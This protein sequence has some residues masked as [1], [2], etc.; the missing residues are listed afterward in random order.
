MLKKLL[1]I[2]LL[3]ACSAFAQ[4][5]INVFISSGVLTLDVERYQSFRVLLNQNVTSVVLQ[6]T[7]AIPSN[8][9]ISITFTQDATGSRTVSFGAVVSNACTVGSTANS[10]TVCQI[11]FDGF[12]NTWTG[13][14]G[15]G[16]SSSPSSLTTFFTGYYGLAPQ[17][18]GAKGDGQV[19]NTCTANNGNTTVTCTAGRFVSADTGKVY[20]LSNGSSP[21]PTVVTGTLTF[22]NATTVTVSVAPNF[23]QASTAVMK[24]GTDDTTALRAWAANISAAGTVHGGYL[25]KGFYYTTKPLRFVA[26]AFGANDCNSP[27]SSASSST[28]NCSIWIQGAGYTVSSIW[29]A[30]AGSF[31]WNA[32][33]TSVNT[34]GMYFA[35]WSGGSLSGFSVNANGTAH[36]T[37]GQ[38]GL[39]AG[40][41]FD[42][43]AHFYVNNTWVQG[44]HNTGVN[45]AGYMTTGNGSGVGAA[46]PCAFESQFNPIISEI[47]DINLWE[48]NASATSEK[49]TYANSFFEHSFNANVIIGAGS[50]SVIKQL[51]FD[52][53]H[54]ITTA[55]GGSAS[56]VFVTNSGVS[57][58]VND[59]IVIANSR[60]Q[61]NVTGAP[62]LGI[63]RFLS[64]T[65]TAFDISNTYIETTGAPSYP[66]I[67]I[68]SGA[69]IKLRI[70]GGALSSGNACAA[71]CIVTNNDAGSFVNI[72]NTG[73]FPAGSTQAFKYGGTSSALVSGFEAV[74]GG[75][76]GPGGNQGTLWISNQGTAAANG[77]VA[78]SA[79]WGTTAAVSAAAGFAQHGRFTVT[80]NGTGQ[81]ANPTITWTLPNALPTA[82][83]LCTAVQV[84]G[85]QA[86]GQ[87]NQTT[88]SA[89][90]PIF[91]YSGTPVAG[92]TVIVDIVCGP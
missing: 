47:N 52:N 84:G 56:H 90:A 43:V 55:N 22:V 89:T 18:F 4:Q 65:A 67:I 19:D 63:L 81:A 59:S 69:N 75:W 40:M 41:M 68:P 87:F 35:N 14:S 45:L 78:L 34:A 16:G 6:T 28:T 11:Q 72:S 7:N 62:I 2:F 60:F 58:G 46:G 91:T 77:Q 73:I 37:T 33:G 88:V 29:V 20:E 31:Q 85:T 3:L 10:T 15:G 32:D 86:Q 23:T 42:N 92:N 1:A 26:P 57:T 82:T 39:V 64:T 83:V 79:G 66:L 25:P 30:T 17:D 27:L 61:A 70:N 38:S 5:T 48:C 36:N 8:K 80:S 49:T 53:D 13:V 74:S 24:W 44:F 71:G 21:T 76:T 12:T 50:G 9:T 54:F 51:R